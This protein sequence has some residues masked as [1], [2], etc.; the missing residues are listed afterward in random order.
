PVCNRRPCPSGHPRLLRR[1]TCETIA[2]PDR[3]G[4]FFAR[5]DAEA[6]IVPR[7][8]T[9][10]AETMLCT[11]G[12]ID[13]SVTSAAATCSTERRHQWTDPHRSI[14]RHHH[15]L[16]PPALPRLRQ[17]GAGASHREL[18]TVARRGD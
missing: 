18:R 3:Y 4:G 10:T 12:R 7:L 13:Q 16:R 11:K 6:R 17:Q 2:P 5:S 1:P 8:T 14:P 15:R 9:R